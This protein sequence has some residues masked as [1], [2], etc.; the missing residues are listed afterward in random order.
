MLSQCYCQ[1]A[2]DKHN[3]HQGVTYLQPGLISS[4]MFDKAP[5]RT[6]CDDRSNAKFQPLE[7]CYKDDLFYSYFERVADRK[8]W[9]FFIRMFGSEE[10]SKKYQA[11][12]M[13]GSSSLERG[14][15]ADAGLK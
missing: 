15:F 14:E 3:L 13:I 1:H 2:R 4:K 12:I 9:F 8:L 6:C 5:D 7:L 10:E 11:T